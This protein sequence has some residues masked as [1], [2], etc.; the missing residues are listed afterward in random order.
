MVLVR[1]GVDCEWWAEIKNLP[2]C[3]DYA[4]WNRADVD[5]GGAVRTTW[6]NDGGHPE[7]GFYTQANVLGPGADGS[8]G[9]QID[10]GGDAPD[11]AAPE[12][13]DPPNGLAWT[14]S[15]SVE[16]D[17]GYE[18]RL[19]AAHS[20]EYSAYDRGWPGSIAPSEVGSAV[21][22]SSKLLHG[23]QNVAMWD[24]IDPGTGQYRA[25]VLTIAGIRC[26]AALPKLGCVDHEDYGQAFAG[27]SGRVRAQATLDSIGSPRNLYVE[28]TFRQTGVP[29][30]AD[31]DDD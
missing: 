14:L 24:L 1:S 22:G 11:D 10:V 16:N 9:A 3:L 8:R 5:S 29:V 27:G 2:M 26:T 21:L 6:Y 4:R 20:S 18:L 25:S 15:M 17:T 19:R 23:P 30:G 13:G 7:G 31:A 12:D 28:M